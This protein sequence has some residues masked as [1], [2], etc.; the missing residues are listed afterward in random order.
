MSFGEKPKGVLSVALLQLLSALVCF[1]IVIL[2]LM[3]L[4][5]A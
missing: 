5:F 4:G 2:T 3:G 1:V